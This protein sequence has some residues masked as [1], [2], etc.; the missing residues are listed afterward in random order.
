MKRT[1]AVVLVGTALALLPAAPASAHPLGNF[2]VNTADRIIVVDGG[3][4]VLHVVDLAEIPTVQ[5]R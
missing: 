4:E 2:T 1:L 3:V 5:A